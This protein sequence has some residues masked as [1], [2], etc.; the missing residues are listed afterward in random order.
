MTEPMMN[1]INEAIE[2]YVTFYAIV[3]AEAGVGRTVKTYSIQNMGD[4]QVTIE[5]IPANVEKIPEDAPIEE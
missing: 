5:R 1:R 2:D 3:M 4:Y